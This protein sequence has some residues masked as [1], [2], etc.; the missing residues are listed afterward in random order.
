MSSVKCDKTINVV[1]SVGLSNV[2][3]GNI[4]SANPHKYVRSLSCNFF[5][6]LTAACEGSIPITFSKFLCSIK[7][8]TNH[9]V[10]QPIS[11]ASFIFVWESNQFP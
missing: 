7:K 10:P 1:K 5:A 11:T 4:S 9:P 8:F 2:I 6:I 3:F